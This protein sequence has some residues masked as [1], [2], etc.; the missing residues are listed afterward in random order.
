M[1]CPATKFGLLIHRLD[2]SLFYWKRESLSHFRCRL[3]HSPLLLVF[4][5][6]VIHRI[7]WWHLA[8]RHVWKRSIT[9]V[10]VQY[11]LQ[12]ITLSICLGK[13]VIAYNI[14][15]KTHSSVKLQF[16][17]NFPLNNSE[18]LLTINWWQFFFAG[19]NLVRI[20]RKKNH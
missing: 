4:F 7:Q 9:F 8:R 19:Y 12:R 3:H 10:L 18:T 17:F 13:T 5:I 1:S 15:S 11:F 16:V 20:M 6:K 2:S 14:K